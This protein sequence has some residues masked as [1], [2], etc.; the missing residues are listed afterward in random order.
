M[1]F[2]YG[3]SNILF[4]SEGQEVDFILYVFTVLILLPFHVRKRSMPHFHGS[5]IVLKWIR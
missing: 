4:R 5:K 1:V 3:E 2:G